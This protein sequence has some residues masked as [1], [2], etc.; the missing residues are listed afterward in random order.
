MSAMD[1]K[2]TYTAFAGPALLAR[3]TLAQVSRAAA[4]QRPEGPAVLVFDDAT[5]QQVDLD[6][7]G[8]ADEPEA[9]APRSP[10]RPKL[11]VVARE[12]T[13]LPRHWEWLAAQPGGASV[14]L[15]KLVD[16]ARRAHSAKDAARAAQERCY[17]FLTAVAGD[18]PSYE[19]ALRALFAG[20]REAFEQAMAGWPE[21]L[22]GYA[23]AL[24]Q[25]AL[26]PQQPPRENDR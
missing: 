26:N 1:Q 12:V 10:G 11:G 5:G 13:L 7:R 4:A 24:A 21:G 17:R 6:A 16:E 14:A 20:R 2:P 9:P 15:R 23:L 25:D 8:V 22:R 18:L 3:G 19:E